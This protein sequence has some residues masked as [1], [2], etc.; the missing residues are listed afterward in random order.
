MT[1]RVASV[2]DV[3]VLWVGLHL[4]RTHQIREGAAP[5]GH[6]RKLCV[7]G[8][9]I[10]G[11]SAARCGLSAARSGKHHGNIFRERG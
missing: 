7:V 11:E 2:G 1:V 3:A 9:G 8:A 4:T 5:N 10:L 6:R